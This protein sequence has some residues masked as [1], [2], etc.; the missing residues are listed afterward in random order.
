MSDHKIKIE[1]H[2]LTGGVWG[3]AWLFTIG[4]LKLGFWQGVAA[5]LIWPYYLGEFFG[6]LI[7][8]N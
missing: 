4:F 7:Q 6:N 3:A 8:L 5:I 2:T 1:Q